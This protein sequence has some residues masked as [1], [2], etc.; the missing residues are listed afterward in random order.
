MSDR[1]NRPSLFL[2]YVCSWK[3]VQPIIKDPCTGHLTHAFLNEAVFDDF[4]DRF[5]KKLREKLTANENKVEVD[6]KSIPCYQEI[7]DF[8]NNEFVI[9]TKDISSDFQITCSYFNLLELKDYT[10]MYFEEGSYSTLLTLI[11]RWWPKYQF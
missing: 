5:F 3:V 7:I 11:H 4:D 6:F 9:V 10:K 2:K 8:I 1:N